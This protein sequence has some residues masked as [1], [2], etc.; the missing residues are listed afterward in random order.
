MRKDVIIMVRSLR[1][2]KDITEKI[3]TG[4]SVTNTTSINERGTT[5]YIQYILEKVID[6]DK[7]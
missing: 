2:T 3:K 6:D 7:E 1:K 4:Y 5:I